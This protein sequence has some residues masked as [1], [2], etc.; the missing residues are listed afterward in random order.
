MRPQKGGKNM[1]DDLIAQINAGILENLEIRPLTRRLVEHLLWDLPLSVPELV[2]F[3]VASPDH[4]RALVAVLKF[5][6]DDEDA[7]RALDE[8]QRRIVELD[9]AYGNSRMLNALI[10]KYAP[11]YAQVVKFT[12][13][14]WDE[15]FGRTEDDHFSQDDEP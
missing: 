9:K 11:E 13:T 5:D 12:P 6:D 7:D 14:P 8:L 10:Q 4:F 1:M 3:S 2:D 15:I